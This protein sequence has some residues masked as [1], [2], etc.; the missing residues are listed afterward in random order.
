MMR[1]KTMAAVFNGFLLLWKL[2]GQSAVRAGKVSGAR[3]TTR[4][5]RYKR[6]A[7]GWHRGEKKIA[8]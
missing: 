4:K 8:A 3:A 6:F 2:R 7:A 1:N 5:R